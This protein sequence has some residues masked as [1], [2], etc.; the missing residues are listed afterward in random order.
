MYTLQQPNSFFSDSI[1]LVAANGEREVLEF[2]IS[3]T[4]ELVKHYRELQVKIINAEKEQDEV[5]RVEQIGEC[6]TSLFVLLFG[7]ENTNKLF[8]FYKNDFPV[9]LSQ[10]FPYIQGE[11]VPKFTAAIKDRK[12]A[13]AKWKQ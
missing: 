9:A 11:I 10:L 6:V 8:A 7:E 12:Q 13:F 5:K 1:E 4:P 3:I 2:S